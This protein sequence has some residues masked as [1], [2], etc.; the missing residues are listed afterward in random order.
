[1]ILYET[2][3]LPST[4][5]VLVKKL[6]FI[7]Y[8]LSSMSRTQNSHWQNKIIMALD[9]MTLSLVSEIFIRQKI[10]PINFFLT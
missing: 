5:P 1:M 10:T 4:Y 8:N 3:D 7:I 9:Q 2:Q 6:F